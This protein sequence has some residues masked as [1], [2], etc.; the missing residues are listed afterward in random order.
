MEQ[1]LLHLVGDYVAQ[2][3]WMARAKVYA[4]LRWL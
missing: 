4:A 3:D 1:L 2:T